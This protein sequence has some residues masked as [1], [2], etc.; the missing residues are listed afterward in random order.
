MKY[1]FHAE[2][3]KYSRRLKHMMLIVSMSIF[4]VCAFCTVNIV[5]NIGS[6][7]AYLLLAII[8]GF[9]FLGMV[10]AFT[11]V[12][13][14]EK[15]KRRHS[16]YTYFDFLPKGMIFSEYA[17][18][19]TR[20]GEKTILRKLYY[21]PFDSVAEVFRDPKTAPHNLTIKGKI[22]AYFQ[23]T[24][25][26]GYHINEDGNLEFDSAELNERLFEIIPE[27]TVRDRFG[28]TKRLEKS[29]NFYLEQ[30]KNTPEKKP[31]N[32]SDYVSV[33]KRVKLYTSN[34]DLETPTYSRNW[35]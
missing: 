2:V 4:A 32:I 13:I 10:F 22:R 28:N 7:I 34:P 14:T 9:V 35:K 21:I 3:E 29:V 17:G 8:G 16:K 1:F 15:Y 23:E 11:A 5:L 24:D 18:E 20:Y 33:R 6:E 25:R 26:L 27:V 31:F 19:F 30:Y 12:Y